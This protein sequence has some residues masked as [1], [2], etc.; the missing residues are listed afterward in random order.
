MKLRLRIHFADFHRYRCGMNSRTGP[1]C[2]GAS[3]SPS[4]LCASK[5]F[6]SI[7]SA[8]GMFV[9]YPPS[10][11][12]ITNPEGVEILASFSKVSIET[13][14]QTV[15][16]FDHLVTQWISVWTSVCGR[17]FRESHDHL[18][19]LSPS[20]SIENSQVAVSTLG[21]GPAERTGKPSSRY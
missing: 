18:P 11:Y 13:P 3:G 21:V 17:A 5:A 7:T 6:P 8:T 20:I 15:S 14:R 19:A 2:S 16:S 10:Q 1:P 4:Y 12:A 9:V